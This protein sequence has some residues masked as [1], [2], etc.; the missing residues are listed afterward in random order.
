MLYYVFF[1][2]RVG[3]E[4]GL[5]VDTATDNTWHQPSNEQNMERD[6]ERIVEEYKNVGLKLDLIMVIFPFK[7]SNVVAHCPQQQHVECLSKDV[8]IFGYFFFII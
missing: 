3:R 4:V 7:V 1:L 6:F 2:F 5:T 8:R